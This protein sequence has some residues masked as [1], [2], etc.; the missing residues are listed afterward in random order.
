MDKNNTQIIAEIGWNHMGKI[1]LAK[2]MILEAKKNGADI[3]KFQTWSEKRLKKGLW[4]SDGRRSIYKKAQLTIKK[5][6]ELIHFCKKYKIEFLTS[7]FTMEDAK[8]M[9]KLGLKKIKIPSHEVCN[10]DL[11]NFALKNFSEVLLSAGACTKR[12]FLNIVKK[13]KNKKNLI[14]M[15]CVSSYPLKAENVNFPKLYEIKKTF[16]NFGYSGHYSSIEDCYV[17][18]ILGAKYVEKHFTINKNNPGRDNKF[19][20]LP[21]ELK[22]L[23]NFRKSFNLMNI[24]KG[25]DLQKCEK[26]IVLKYRGRWN[27]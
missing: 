5:H 4:D 3:C 20:I 8:E 23:D 6:K 27:G 16:T 12:E 25:L 19:A 13:Y 17:P 10:L 9:K 26:D 1:S 11:I 22:D 21:K 15:H 2:K 14:V 24:N 18:I 7:V